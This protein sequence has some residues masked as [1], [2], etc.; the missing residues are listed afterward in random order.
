MSYAR[1]RMVECYFWSNMVYYEQE[2]RRARVILAKIIALTSLLDDTYDSY[3]TLED[4]R[5]L[6]EAIQR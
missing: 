5:K 2:H 3:A 1:D 4:S 6:N